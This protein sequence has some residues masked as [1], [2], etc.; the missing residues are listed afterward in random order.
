MAAGRSVVIK[1]AAMRFMHGYTVFIVGETKYTKRLLLRNC[2]GTTSSVVLSAKAHK[3][4]K[5]QFTT[6]LFY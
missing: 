5:Y 1:M 4:T 6:S 3:T 2:L